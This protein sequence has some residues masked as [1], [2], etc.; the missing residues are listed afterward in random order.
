MTGVVC[1]VSCLSLLIPCPSFSSS[2]SSWSSRYSPRSHGLPFLSHTINRGSIV[3]HPQEQ[4]RRRSLVLCR[5]SSLVLLPRVVS[6]CSTA[7]AQSAS[8]SRLTLPNTFRP[9]VSH[10]EEQVRLCSLC[11]VLPAGAQT[12][13]LPRYICCSSVITRSEFSPHFVDADLFPVH[14]QPLGQG[15]SAVCRCQIIAHTPSVCFRPALAGSANVPSQPPNWRARRSECSLSSHCVWS[16]L[17]SLPGWRGTSKTG[18]TLHGLPPGFCRRVEAGLDTVEGQDRSSCGTPA[19]PSSC[20]S[21]ALRFSI[22]TLC[23]CTTRL[24]RYGAP[25]LSKDMADSVAVRCVSRSSSVTPILSAFQAW[26][27]T[28]E[29]TSPLAGLK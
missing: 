20:R 28:P 11:H 14:H 9:I 18:L 8:S 21:C 22:L 3:N 4:V 17:M 15:T 24:V 7:I 25:L 19:S 23:G 5:R 12:P 29:A 1:S 16:W 26:T 6:S 13:N 27:P 2:G 10:Y